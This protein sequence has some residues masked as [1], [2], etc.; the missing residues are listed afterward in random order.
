MKTKQIIFAVLDSVFKVAL[1]IVIVYFVYQ[2]AMLAYDYGYRVFTEPAIAQEG[3]GIEITV[4]TTKKSEREVGL[5]LEDKGLVRDGNLFY[6]QILLSEYRGKL[7]PGT[8]VLSTEMT[9]REMIEILST[10]PEEEPEE[11]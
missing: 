6:V 5:L 4:D 11:E 2:G 10:E 3:Q 1:A 9:P 8:Y 7:L